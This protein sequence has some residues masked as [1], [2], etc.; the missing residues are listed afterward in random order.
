MATVLIPW[1]PQPSR[2]EAFE[3]VQ[4]WYRENLPEVELRTIDSDDEVF[5]LA[6]CRNLAVASATDPN[7]VLILN[8]ADTIPERA[9]LMA[10]IEAAA[11]SPLVQLPYTDYRWLGVEG[12]A[13]LL[14]GTTVRGCAF[15]LVVG[16]CSGIYVTTARTWWSHGGQDE[17]FRGWGFEDAAWYVAHETLLGEPPQRH[18]G[19]VF[20]LAHDLEARHGP[21]FDANARLMQRYRD[22]AGK[23]EAMS[24]FVFSA[25]NA[26]SR[27]AS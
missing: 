3:A 1:R 16:A 10:A 26:R 19:A 25:E 8:D 4:G 22:A 23:S 14:A 11:H 17:R 18:P 24:Q 6:R 12:T 27:P 13:E 7:A 2:V 20:A 5:N 15:E 9:P 21:E